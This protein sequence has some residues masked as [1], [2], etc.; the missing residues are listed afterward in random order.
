M[1]IPEESNEQLEKE[2]N[3]N[4]ARASIASKQA[5]EKSVIIEA[6]LSEMVK[7]TVN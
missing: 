4:I 7:K 1:L 5:G 6:I 2:F 3:V